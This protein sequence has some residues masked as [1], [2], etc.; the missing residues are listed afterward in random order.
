MPRNTKQGHRIR[1]IQYNMKPATDPRQHMEISLPQ[2][3]TNGNE[4]RPCC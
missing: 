3:A 2:N 4:P 1:A